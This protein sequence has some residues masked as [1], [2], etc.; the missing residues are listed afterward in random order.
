[1]SP[2]DEEMLERL[3]RITIDILVK[4]LNKIPDLNEEKLDSI[5]GKNAL[6]R[7]EIILTENNRVENIRAKTSK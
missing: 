7:N 2:I 6:I 5:V 3:R 1:M 4:E